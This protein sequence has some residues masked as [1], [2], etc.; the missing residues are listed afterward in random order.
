MTSVSKYKENISSFCQENGALS[1]GLCQWFSGKESACNAGD[2]AG[3]LGLIP[4][5][6]VLWR[7]KWQPTPIFLP[8]KSPEQNKLVVYSSWDHKRVRHDL[9]TSKGKDPD[10]GRD[11]GQEENGA[12][13]DEMAGWHHRLDRHE[14]E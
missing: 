9:E 7:R 8:G 10:A 14:F 3:A 2:A 4:G 12:T 6:E 5:W 13:E 1:K 11:W